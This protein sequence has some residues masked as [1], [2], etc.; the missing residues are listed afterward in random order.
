MSIE[1]VSLAL[2][3]KIGGLRKLL[4]RKHERKIKELDRR[5]TVLTLLCVFTR[6]GVEEISLSEVLESI[7]HLQNSYDL[8]Y[9]YWSRFLY[10]PG[11]IRD[12]TVLQD[13]GYLKRYQY[14]HDAFLPKQFL[15]LTHLGTGT[16]KRYSEQ[17]SE[18]VRK[19][20]ELAVDTAVCASQQQRFRPIAMD[21]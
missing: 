3:G 12:L 20:V 21:C 1:R 10:S 9:E 17:V 5:K 6:K 4:V 7:Q 13:Q 8:G 14:R 18:D 16:G 15:S 11:V 19:A 2:G